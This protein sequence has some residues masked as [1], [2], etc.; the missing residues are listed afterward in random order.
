MMKIDVSIRDVKRGMSINMSM[1]EYIEFIKEQAKLLNV[2][3][4]VKPMNLASSVEFPKHIHMPFTSTKSTKDFLDMVEK[5]MRK[6]KKRGV[7]A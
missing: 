6:T 3:K 4:E 5:E 2:E 7:N 1:E